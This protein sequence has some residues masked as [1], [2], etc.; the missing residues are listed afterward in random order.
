MPISKHRWLNHID[1]PDEVLQYF[2]TSSPQHAKTLLPCFY[3]VYNL[4]K[5]KMELIY[6][7]YLL[8]HAFYLHVHVLCIYIYILLHAYYILGNSKFNN[9][10][11]KHYGGNRY[12][13][14]CSWNNTV[15]LFHILYYSLP[16]PTYEY[17]HT[18]KKHTQSKPRASA[19]SERSSW[20]SFLSS[21]SKKELLLSREVWRGKINNDNKKTRQSLLIYFYFHFSL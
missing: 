20:E 10:R 2:F 7:L 5:Y 3:E 15:V 6:I 1:Q 12:N 16:A 11:T 19:A 18:H 8:I 9:T 17:I 13:L 14:F 21:V 4:Y